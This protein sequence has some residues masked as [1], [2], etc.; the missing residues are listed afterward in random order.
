MRK[1]REAIEFVGLPSDALLR[2]G[3]KRIVYGIPLAANFRPYLLGLDARPKYIIP[4]KDA[5]S[6]TQRLIEYWR[7]R[8]LIRR[9]ASDEVLRKVS[10]HTLSYPVRHGAQV[11]LPDEEEKSMFTM[12]AGA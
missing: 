6:G 9:I 11:P 10:V 3:N 5:T 8:W 1:M 12:S 4:Q 2:H 7:N